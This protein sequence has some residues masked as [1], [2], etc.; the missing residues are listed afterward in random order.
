MCNNSQQIASQVPSWS[1]LVTVQATD[2]WITIPERRRSEARGWAIWAGHFWH[3]AMIQHSETAILASFTNITIHI[4]MYINYKF[5]CIILKLYFINLDFINLDSMLVYW[6]INQRGI[7]VESI[8]MNIPIQFPPWDDNPI[9][10]AELI[11]PL[12][13]TNS[14][15]T[16]NQLVNQTRVFCCKMAGI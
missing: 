12:V 2:S 13:K 1:V 4:M 16:L 8:S 6:I 14:M 5:I 3:R 7:N 10:I 9:G 15:K 11:Q